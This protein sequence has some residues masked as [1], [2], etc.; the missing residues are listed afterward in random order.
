VPATKML[1]LRL[2]D[3]LRQ[4]VELFQNESNLPSISA[5]VRTL[6]TIGLDKTSKLEP[7]WRSVVATEAIK[8]Y[9]GRVLQVMQ[10]ALTKENLDR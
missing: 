7:A 4:R 3:D 2:D 1:V 6:L 5:A 8:F 10:Q 9:R